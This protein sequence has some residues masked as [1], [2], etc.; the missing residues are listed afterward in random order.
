MVLP[1]NPVTEYVVTF[2]TFKSLKPETKLA[3]VLL[4]ETSNRYPVAPVTAPQ[5]AEKVV[6]VILEADVAVEV[7]GAVNCV[8]VLELLLVPPVL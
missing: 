6:L 1:V 4:A 2:E 8:I 5:F 3:K 7:V